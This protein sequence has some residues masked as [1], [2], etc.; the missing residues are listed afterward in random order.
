[1]VSLLSIFVSA[2]GESDADRYEKNKAELIET[3]KD[4]DVAKAVYEASRSASGNVGEMER[5]KI[6]ED[7][8]IDSFMLKK[9]GTIAA[10]SMIDALNGANELAKKADKSNGEYIAASQLPLP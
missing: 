10:A 4:P 1:M 7:N 9:Y 6:S 2:C 3:L 8:K 5:K